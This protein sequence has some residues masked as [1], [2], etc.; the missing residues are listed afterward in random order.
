MATSSTEAEDVAAAN[1]C[2]QECGAS[3]SA[4]VY[5]SSLHSQ[6]HAHMCFCCFLMLVKCFADV[7]ISIPSGRTFIVPA[8]R[9]EHGDTR[10][11]IG[12]WVEVQVGTYRRYVTPKVLPSRERVAVVCVRESARLACRLPI[13]ADTSPLRERLVTGGLG[14]GVL[15][16][17]IDA[18]A[19]CMRVPCAQSQDGE[20]GGSLS[21]GPCVAAFTRSFEPASTEMYAML[22]TA[23]Y[24]ALMALEAR[25]V[26]NHI[27]PLR[28]CRGRLAE[29]ESKGKVYLGCC[30]IAG[31]SSEVAV[32]AK[33]VFLGA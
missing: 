15:C 23:F 17:Q 18:I 32:F 27:T 33:G 14:E 24:Y 21:F 6:H 26:V 12:P 3:E 19:M 25:C 29:Y 22:E 16:A 20:F 11:L 5:V 31:E 9:S 1:C 10:L 2:R 8:G 13:E 7:P 30:A 28:L 4:G